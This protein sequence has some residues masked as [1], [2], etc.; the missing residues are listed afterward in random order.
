MS[1]LYFIVT[2]IQ[3]WMKQYMIEVMGVDN[4]LAD[5]LFIVFCLTAAPSGVIFGGFFVQ[6]KGSYESINAMYFLLF[7][8]SVCCSISVSFLFI[9]NKF[10]FMPL[11][12]AFVFFGSAI[13]PTIGGSV[14][15]ALPLELKGSGNSLQN[16]LVSI[17]G[18]TPAPFIYGFIHDKT[19]NFMPTLAFSICMSVSFIAFFLIIW[20][21]NIRKAEE[22]HENYF[23]E[24]DNLKYSENKYNISNSQNDNT[25][26]EPKTITNFLV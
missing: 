18:Y 12:W 9:T 14:L 5:L 2:V 26:K 11:I 25:K 3:Q 4:K 22:K 19:K 17:F 7:N 23:N 13:T 1:V 16:I 8:I 6:R 24:N 10:I 21:I 15:S 20:I